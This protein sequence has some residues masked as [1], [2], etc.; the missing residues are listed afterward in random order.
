MSQLDVIVIGGGIAGLASGARLADEGYRVRVLEQSE[1]VGGYAGCFE[2]GGYR[3]D[4]GAHH[5]GGL[6]EGDVLD[7]LLTRLGVREE[8]EAI[9][10][11]PLQA[12]FGGE[13]VP[14]P[15]SMEELLRVLTEAAPGDRTALLGITEEIRAFSRALISSDGN[16]IYEFFKKWSS[17]TWGAYLA[18]RITS[19]QA[20]GILSALGPGYGGITANGSALAM[21]SLLATYHEGAFYIKGGT[22]RLPDLLAAAIEQRGGEVWTEAS[23]EQILVEDKRVT[24]VVCRRGEDVV[25]MR[26]PV[27][28]VASSLRSAYQMIDP[29]AIGDRFKQRLGQMKVGPSAFRLYLSAKEGYKPVGN[30][31]LYF[32]GWDARQWDDDV[33]YSTFR[34]SDERMPATLVCFPSMVDRSLAP[35]D[36][37]VMFMTILTHETEQTATPEL[38]ERML[39]IAERMAPGIRGAALHYEIAVPQTFHRRTRNDR[40]S[41]FGWERSPEQSLRTNALAPKGALSG[42]YVAGQWG[43]NNG[44]YGGALTAEAAAVAILSERAKLAL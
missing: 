17:V 9:P 2:R 42:L 16:A 8:I 43:P 35:P 44:I 21:A 13:T 23:A 20:L 15:F 29:A 11:P 41:V 18:D 28:L 27:V 38:Q 40:G 37:H 6:A 32:P 36:A 25:E 22:H 1:S 33:F 34:H 7:R 26:A 12:T 3:F 24:G 10:S 14:V 39:Q 4:T 5:I 31:L 19:L 30:D